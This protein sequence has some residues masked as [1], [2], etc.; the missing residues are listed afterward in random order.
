[1]IHS[2]LFGILVASFINFIVG[3]SSIFLKCSVYIQWV[4]ETLKVVPKNYLIASYTC[5]DK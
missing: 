3:V 1:M 4:N 5:F 2:K